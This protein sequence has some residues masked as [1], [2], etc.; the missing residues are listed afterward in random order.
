MDEITRIREAGIAQQPARLA[1]HTVVGDYHQLTFEVEHIA[2]MARPGQF[3]TVTVGGE[4]SGALLRRSFSISSATPGDGN[5]PGRVGLVVSARGQGTHWLVSL[6][7]GAE[8]DMVGP[9]GRPFPLPTSPVPCILVGGGYGS[10]PLFW[11]AQV[12]QERDCPPAMILGAATRDRLYGVTRAADVTDQVTVTTDDGSLGV[13]GWVSDVLADVV[14]RTGAGAIY[15]CGPMPM[16]RS[17]SEIA[18][19]TGAIAQVAVE[20]AMACGIGVCMTCVMP[21]EGRDG[22]TRMVRSCVEGPTFRGDR[23]RWDAFDDGRCH[24]PPDAVGAPRAGGH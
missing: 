22:A 7:P 16:L 18:A 11:L 20:E 17:V 1:D 13:K 14:D 10:A 9:S 24:V 8:V 19:A 4:M 15:A 21:V 23:V 2:E 6:T 3:V 12:L 5:T